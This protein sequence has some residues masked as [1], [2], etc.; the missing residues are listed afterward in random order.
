MTGAQILILE[1]DPDVGVDLACTLR[2]GGY[3]VV[4]MNDGR[5]GLRAALA[6]P[7]ALILIDLLIPPIHGLDACRRLRVDPKTCKVPVLLLARQVNDET[8]AAALEA[9]ADGCLGRSIVSSDLLP[10]VKAL[11][12]RDGASTP[13]GVLEYG[14]VLLDRV[15][16][17]VF[18]GNREAN[19]TP[20]EFRLLAWLMLEPGR[21]FSR[22]ELVD[23]AVPHG[24]A[25]D[26]VVDVHIKMLRKKLVLPGLIEA[27]RRVG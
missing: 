1:H 23:A 9:G 3:E 14:G 8:K 21:S 26:R 18:V 17:W 24:D 19:L 10:H 7:P 13:G 22:S 20:T 4:V 12:L 6:A 11:L 16:H 2:N 25:S 27:V 5:E 15:H